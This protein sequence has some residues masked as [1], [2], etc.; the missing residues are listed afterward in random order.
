MRY[1][2]DERI[3]NLENFMK[4]NINVFKILLLLVVLNN[5]ALLSA[6]TDLTH[7]FIKIYNQKRDFTLE[8]QKRLR[9]YDI[10]F[11]PGILAESLISNDPDSSIN[12]S[13][14]TEDYFGTQLE[15]LN[16]K[17]KIPAKRIK[18]SSHDV[19][20]TRKNISEAVNS[21]KSKGRKVII[22]S[23]SLGGL[24]LLEELILNPEIQNNIAGIVFLQSPFYGTPI[25]QV[26]LKA[27]PFINK[28]IKITMPFVNV[29]DK[30][31]E[32]VGYVARETYMKKNEQDIKKLLAK[33]PSYTFAGI[34]EGNKSLFKPM[35]DIMESGCLKGITD[36]CITE[37]FYPGP[38]D[39][40][41]GLIPL[42][43]AHLYDADFVALEKADHGEII[44]RMPFEDYNK[45][46][47]TTTWLRVL[48]KKMN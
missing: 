37:K 45:E 24:A 12:I 11:I 43:S 15:F 48:L 1:N 16:N 34:A 27:P 2:K 17:Y 33:V 19:A 28:L 42:K 41:D 29:S 38:Y 4:K 8:E 47:L 9:E 23:H 6:K 30:T 39:K 3:I 26:M 32:Y 25:G 7:D 46:Q 20:I 36:K 40:N 22:L 10:Y 5:P 21:S 35:I 14:L 44:L 31:L 18:T 13:I